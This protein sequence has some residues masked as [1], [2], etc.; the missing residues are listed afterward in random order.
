[1]STFNIMK[2]TNFHKC[3]TDVIKNIQFGLSPKRCF[4]NVGGHRFL[5]GCV[6]I[7]RDVV[8]TR[9]VSSKVVAL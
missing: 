8:K 3:F 9:A 1:M 6:K 2:K 4:S 7:Q 5:K